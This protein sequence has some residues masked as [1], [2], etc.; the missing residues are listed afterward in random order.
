MPWA[1]MHKAALHAHIPQPIVVFTLFRGKTPKLLKMVLDTGATYT[2]IP[3]KAAVAMGCDPARSRR[4]IQ[5]VTAS[6]VE[7]VPLVVVPKVHCLGVEVTKLEV[8][9]HDL[10]PASTVEGLLGL[11]FLIHFEPFQHFLKALGTSLT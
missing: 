9:C 7:Y 2:V 8:V 1:F 4:R 6:G 5:M 10:P 3:A 11:N